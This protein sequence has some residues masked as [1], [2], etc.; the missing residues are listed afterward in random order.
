MS[1]EPSSLEYRSLKVYMTW[2]CPCG[3]YNESAADQTTL[4]M[5]EDGR[6]YQFDVPVKPVSCV[7]CG[8]KFWLAKPGQ[9]SRLA[10]DLYA[11]DFDE[12]EDDDEDENDDF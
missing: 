2:V 9:L 6:S 7:E 8:K 11:I 1:T 4:D 12:D 10:D 3:A 5:T